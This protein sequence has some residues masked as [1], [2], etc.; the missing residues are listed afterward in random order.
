MTR[1]QTHLQAADLTDLQAADLQAADPT[2]LQA[3]D[4][5][6]A[7][8]QAAE[9]PTDLQAADLQAADLRAADPMD[10]RAAHLLAADLAAGPMDLRGAHLLAAGAVMVRPAVTDLPLAAAERTGRLM[11]VTDRRPGL[12]VGAV[13]LQAAEPAFQSHLLRPKRRRA[14]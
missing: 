14:Q 1:R 9:D 8:L 2:D 4:L 7:H 11:A 13:G 5:Q 10:L 6:A 12:L 3:A